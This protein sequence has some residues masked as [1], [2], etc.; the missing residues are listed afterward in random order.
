MLQRSVNL[1]GKMKIVL[2]L[3]HQ[4]IVLVLHAIERVQYL[5]NYC[6]VCEIDFVG[7]M[8]ILV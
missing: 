3:I 7:W 8:Q 4:I 6:Y 1:P 5:T 2:N